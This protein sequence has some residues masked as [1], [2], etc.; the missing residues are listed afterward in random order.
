VRR[1]RIEIDETFLDEVMADVR[2]SVETLAKSR[3]QKPKARASEIWT[4]M[5][6]ILIV[7]QRVAP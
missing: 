2:E 6:R 1:I 7:V 3:A 4:P 5:G